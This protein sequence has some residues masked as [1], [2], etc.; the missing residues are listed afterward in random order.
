ME[1]NSKESR[2]KEHGRGSDEN[3]DV[4]RRRKQKKRRSYTSKGIDGN[5]GA[6]YDG[7]C[8]GEFATK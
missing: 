6:E 5:Y 8:G 2:R 7:V 1:V 3:V 4:G